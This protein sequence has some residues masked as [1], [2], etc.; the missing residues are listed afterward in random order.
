MSPDW[1]AAPMGV[2]Y[3]DFGNPQSLNLYSYVKNNPLNLTDPDGHC[4]ADGEKHNWVWCAAHSLGLTQ[5]QKE[6]VDQARSDLAGMKNFTINGQTPQ[7]FAK[8]A[9]DKQVLAAERA[10]TEFAVGQAMDTL[11][12]ICPKGMSCGV[13][14]L[15]LGSTGRT[16]AANLKEKLAMEEVMAEP[17]GTKLPLQ[18]NDSR[19]PAGGGWVKMS[20]TVNGVEIHWVENLIT[21]AVD[22]FK[23][24]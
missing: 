9:S 10:V 22:D 1:S 24:K 19:W 6:K 18:M 7:D 15:G 5:T 11:F 21:G 23:F 13:I 17:K 12:R 3:A 20:Q 4:T 8:N 14:P 16:V 2:P